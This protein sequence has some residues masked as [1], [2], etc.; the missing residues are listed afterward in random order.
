MCL[1]SLGPLYDVRTSTL[2]F[3]DIEKCKVGSLR[4]YEG[5]ASRIF[6]VFHLNVD[7]LDLVTEVF[8]VP[9][10]SLALRKQGAG[11]S[12]RYCRRFASCTDSPY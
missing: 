7:T 6:K 9:V 8:D 11:V 5:S 10:T 3:L 2:H 4:K 12:A 1:F